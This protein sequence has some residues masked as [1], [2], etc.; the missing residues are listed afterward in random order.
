MIFKRHRH[1]RHGHG[2]RRRRRFGPGFGPWA[3]WND[4]FEQ[5]DEDETEEMPPKDA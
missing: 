5:S 1:G 3:W 4:W 2:H